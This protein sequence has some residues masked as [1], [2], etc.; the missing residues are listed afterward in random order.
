MPR[1]FRIV[2][3]GLLLSYFSLEAVGQ[4]QKYTTSDRTAP[5]SGPTNN[6]GDL[7]SKGLNP[8]ID[9]TQY[10]VRA[11]SKPPATT[12]SINRGTNK[13]TVA[14][15]SGFVNGDGIVVRGAGANTVLKNPSAPTVTAS[16]AAVLTGT[17]LTVE[18][19]L[20]GSVYQYQIVA[21]DIG[22]GYTV[23]SPVTSIANGPSA[24]GSVSV[25]VSSW[26]A[27]NTVVTVTT[28]SAHSLVAGQMVLIAGAGAANGWGQ[29]ATGPPGTSFKF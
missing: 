1:S 25:N 21:R 14:S 19:T 24:L 23:A 7:R 18:N 16:G 8:Y 3:V 27:N 13:L 29:A 22:G 26:T 9:V 12:G 2:A 20:G 17:G 10:G 28:G 5:P 15:G 6:P 4:N 11:V